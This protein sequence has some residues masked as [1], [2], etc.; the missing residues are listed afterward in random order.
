MKT[1]GASERHQNNTLKICIA[2]AFFIGK[3]TTF[4]DINRKSQIIAFLD[5]KIKSQEEDPDQKWITTWNYNLVHL[6]RLFRWLHN[7]HESKHGYEQKE[8]AE[9]EEIPESEWVTPSFIKN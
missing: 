8:E 1:N 7:C 4:Y 3:D 6:K 2:F 9:I 5:T